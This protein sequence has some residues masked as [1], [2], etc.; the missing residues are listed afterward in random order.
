MRARKAA[1]CPDLIS[2]SAQAMSRSDIDAGEI[3]LR[4]QAE[5]AV[6]Y[7]DSFDIVG[8]ARQK[9]TSLPGLTRQSNFLRKK[10]F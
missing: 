10:A 4:S 8:R 6:G 7:F 5:D 9:R 1:Y 3:G 2:A